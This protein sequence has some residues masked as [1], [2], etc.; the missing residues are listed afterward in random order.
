MVVNLWNSPSSIRMANEGNLRGDIRVYAAQ[1]AL[2]ALG[3]YTG[4]LDG[5][6]GNQTAAAV[7]NFQ[8][9]QKVE[10][11]GVIGTQTWPLLAGLAKE[12]SDGT[13]TVVPGAGA[14]TGATVTEF[15]TVNKVTKP[16]WTEA[17][18]G[19]F[20]PKYSFATVLDVKTG[21]VFTIY[22][23]GG[24]NHPD[25][26]PYTTNDTKTMC[27]IVGFTYPNR[28]PTSE[29]LKKIV[30]DSPNSNTSYTWPDF[31]G[32]LTGVASIGSAWDRRPALL[33]VNGNV[34]AVSIYGWPHGFE[35]IGASDGLSTQKFPNGKLLYENN[36][37]YGCMCIRF[38][39]SKGH[40]SANQTVINEHN[41]AINT[42]YNYAKTKW[43]TL[44]K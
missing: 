17:D 22:R 26:V 8:R 13:T 6:Y 37:F 20:W 35:G 3:Y 42:A 11:D 2:Y 27:E 40:G 24:S 29:E 43:P 41:N 5:S 15:G 23:T 21:K 44:C 28:R 9:A 10:A 31:K 7:K 36:N 32:K 18:N 34:Y 4:T 12:I 19:N 1:L 14:G 25:A 33:N 16:T 30:A 38:Y 39:N